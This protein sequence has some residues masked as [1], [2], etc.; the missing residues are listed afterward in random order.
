VSSLVLQFLGRSAFFSVAE[1]VPG[2]EMGVKTKVFVT[3]RIHCFRVSAPWSAEKTFG[4]I[5]LNGP[6]SSNRTVKNLSPLDS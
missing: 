6:T 1:E 4:A 5:R 2:A 3:A